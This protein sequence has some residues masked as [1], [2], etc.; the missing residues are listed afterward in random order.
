MMTRRRTCEGKIW[1]LQRSEA[2]IPEPGREEACC[3]IR[4]MKEG[5]HIKANSGDTTALSTVRGACT[6]GSFVGRQQL[7]EGAPV[8]HMPICGRKIKSVL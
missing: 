7:I 1:H 2:M 8:S 3:E 5:P 6:V 4:S